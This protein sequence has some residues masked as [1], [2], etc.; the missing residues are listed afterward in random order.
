M[1]L[2]K[3]YIYVSCVALSQGEYAVVYFSNHHRLIISRCFHRNFAASGIIT[4][5]KLVLVS[6]LIAFLLTPLLRNK[7]ARSSV[8]GILQSHNT[9]VKKLLV[10]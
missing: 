5:N 7:F 10:N 4:R 1:A 3:I 9:E 2:K 8:L 6:N